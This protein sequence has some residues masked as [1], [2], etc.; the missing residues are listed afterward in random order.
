MS[1]VNMASECRSEPQGGPARRVYSSTPLTLFAWLRARVRPSV[2]H[3]HVH[4]SQQREDILLFSTNLCMPS[5]WQKIASALIWLL[6]WLS[7][8]K[9]KFWENFRGVPWCFFGVWKSGF[10]S[11]N[12][13][14]RKCT[15]LAGSTL[16]RIRDG[17]DKCVCVQH[18]NRVCVHSLT[19]VQQVTPK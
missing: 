2:V 9:T 4:C 10:N 3:V 1:C 18:E 16:H 12:Q 7:I 15:L 19:C 13:N 11:W 14:F 17:T 6:Y 5:K 8:G